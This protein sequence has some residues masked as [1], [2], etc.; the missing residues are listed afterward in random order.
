MLQVS[1]KLEQG[2][3]HH[4]KSRRPEICRSIFL[5]GQL[6]ARKTWLLLENV[7]DTDDIRCSLSLS[8]PPLL[9]S[10]VPAQGE[11]Q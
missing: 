11:N 3:R 4:L 7:K 2:T 8:F 9:L 1:V 5:V 10:S 6:T